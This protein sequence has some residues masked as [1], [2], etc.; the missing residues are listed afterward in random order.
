MP[1]D[2]GKRKYARFLLFIPSED[3]LYSSTSWFLLQV[4]ELLKSINRQVL[5][6]TF[7]WPNRDFG[8][9]SARR[10]RSRNL[11]L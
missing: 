5:P 3:S 1:G 10:M 7:S 11:F 9:I 4:V 6:V 8:R 2:V